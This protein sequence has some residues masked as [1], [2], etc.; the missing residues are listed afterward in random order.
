MSKLFND[1]FS[2]ISKY[3]YY[4]VFVLGT[5]F[6]GF[7][8]EN[9]FLKRIEY[10]YQIKKMNEDIEKFESKYYHDLKSLSDLQKN[11]TTITKI[12][13]KTYFMKADDEDIFVLSDD[14]DTDNNDNN[15]FYETTE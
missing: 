14:E 8:G 6:V 13:R 12:A 1:I 5:L 3:K 7:L 10:Y 11:P 4:I 2:K 9:S 15:E